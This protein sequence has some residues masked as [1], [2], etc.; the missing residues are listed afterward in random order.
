MLQ[1]CSPKFR[2]HGLPEFISMG[3]RTHIQALGIVQRMIDPLGLISPAPR[4]KFKKKHIA[5][6]TLSGKLR[7]TFFESMNNMVYLRLLPI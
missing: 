3:Y 5:R 1:I 7:N 6:F 4:G 2:D